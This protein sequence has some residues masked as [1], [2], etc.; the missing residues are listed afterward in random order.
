MHEWLLGIPSVSDVGILNGD[1]PL[2]TMDHPDADLSCLPLDWRLMPELGRRRKVHQW[3][4]PG[5]VSDSE[6][7]YDYYQGKYPDRMDFDNPSFLLNPLKL[8]FKPKP[9]VHVKEPMEKAVRHISPKDTEEPVVL[10]YYTVR[11]KTK[12]AL[13]FDLHEFGCRWVAFS[14]MIDVGPKTLVVPNWMV[15]KWIN[16]PPIAVFE[17]PHESSI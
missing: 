14:K 5:A 13:M 9:V 12:K 11:R 7:D 8:E 4:L 2:S 3:E 10:P 15:Q 16:T 1:D 6:D 17:R